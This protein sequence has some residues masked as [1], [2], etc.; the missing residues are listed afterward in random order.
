MGNNARYAADQEVG[1][2]AGASY[3]LGAATLLFPS[4]RMVHIV[5]VFGPCQILRRGLALGTF[6]QL[7]SHVCEK[8]R[9]GQGKRAQ[10]DRWIRGMA[11]VEGESEPVATNDAC[12][13]GWNETSDEKKDVRRQKR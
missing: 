2:E 3:D 1:D 8:G 7:S 12:S 9:P 11:V 5:R 13:A 4:R 10:E 6:A